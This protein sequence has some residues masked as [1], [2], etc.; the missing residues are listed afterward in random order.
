[1][2]RKRF[3]AV[4]SPRGPVAFHNL[5][6]FSLLLAGLSAHVIPGGAVTKA[7]AQP[8][9]LTIEGIYGEP[10]LYADVPS[11]IRWLGNS[12]GISYLETRGE[13]DDEQTYFIIRDVPSGKERIICIQDTVAIPEDLRQSDDDVFDFGSYEWSPKNELIVFTYEGDIFTMDRKNARIIRRTRTESEEEDPTFSPDG[14][15]LAYTRDNDIYV[16]ELDAAEEIRLTTSGSDSLLNGVLDYVYMEELFTR[17]D[18]KAFYWSPDGERL[19]FLQ[20]DT[21]PVPEFPLVHWVSSKAG[22]ELQRYPKAGDP[23]SMVRVGIVPAEGG[24]VTWVDTDTSDDSYIARI[25]WLGD[26]RAVAVEKLNRNQDH[27]TLLFADV[28]TGRTTLV[29]EE[30]DQAWINVTYMQ[31]FFENERLFIWSSERSGN[32]HLYLYNIDGSPIRPLTA[33]DWEV[34]DLDGVDEDDHVVYFTANKKHLAERHL[35]RV[36]ERGGEIKQITDGEGSHR[37]EMSPNHEYFVDRYSNETRPTRISVYSVKGKKLFDVGDQLSPDLAAIEW[38]KPELLTFKSGTGLEYYCMITKPSD[39]NRLRK[40]PVI[41]YT[42]G[43]PHAQVVS[44]SWSS[45]HLFHALMAD[46]GYIVFSLDNRGSFGRGRDWENHVF[47]N[48]GRYELEDQLAGI[49]YLRTLPYVDADNI[50]IWGWSYGGY[51]TLMALFKSPGVFKAGV[52]VAPTTD[53]HLYDSIYTERYMK[54]P[55]DN[56]DGYKDSSPLNF[57]DDFEG[58]LLLMYGDADDNVHAQHSLKLI[59]KLIKAGKDFDLM[60]FPDKRHSIRGDAEQVFLYT[61]MAGFFDEHLLQS[62]K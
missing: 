31:H 10:S 45:R 8:T 5:F 47:K 9:K 37:V 7:V 4:V 23:N 12:K 25:H 50:G 1:M 56:E 59:Q 61:K 29:F 53:W 30:T 28:S 44:R 32:A 11:D 57:V 16:L 52:A 22:Y 39:F 34:T 17:G 62:G 38:S 13:G 40:Y 19:A 6:V 27:L 3:A 36:S 41:V 35:Y 48:L 46:R 60:V 58:N 2:I 18:L 21:S 51:M 26:S 14:K 55:V 33:G 49:E 24:D 20:F 42:Y 43:G 15:K 54:L